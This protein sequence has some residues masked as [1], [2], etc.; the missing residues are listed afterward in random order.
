MR[1]TS[2]D[3]I[4]GPCNDIYMLDWSTLRDFTLSVFKYYLQSEGSKEDD[5]SRADIL[6]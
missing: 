2:R 5:V 6:H 1:G 4:D 3:T